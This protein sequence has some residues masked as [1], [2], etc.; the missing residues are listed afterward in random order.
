M[1]G[2]LGSS[3]LSIYPRVVRA[4]LNHRS[5]KVLDGRKRM[6]VRWFV[7]V[8]C[9]CVAQTVFTWFWPS[10]QLSRPKN[11][12]S[13]GRTWFNRERNAA[14]YTPLSDAQ[15]VVVRRMHRKLTK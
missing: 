15:L 2:L 12:Y 10:W 13:L 9:V 1:T 3:P 5:R 6:E 8:F 4:L 11:L 14:E 7:L